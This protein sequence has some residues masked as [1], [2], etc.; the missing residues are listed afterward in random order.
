MAAAEL[1][2]TSRTYLQ[3]RESADDPHLLP[4]FEYLDFS[5]DDFQNVV[6]AAAPE[7]LPDPAQDR[8]PDQSG[9]VP[10]MS[11]P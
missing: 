6:L 7:G 2:G 8:R 3:A 10:E 11:W 5:L 1:N 4:L 9:P